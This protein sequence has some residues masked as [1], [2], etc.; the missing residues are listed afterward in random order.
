[1]KLPAILLLL[2]LL[3]PMAPAAAAPVLQP[4]RTVPLVTT[5]TTA[6]PVLSHVRVTVMTTPASFTC[7][8]PAVCI[9]EQDAIEKWGE[10]KYVRDSDQSCG[11]GSSGTQGRPV[12]MY[13]YREV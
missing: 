3:L 11:T 6:V 12:L 10:N 13:C 2:I 8:V 7:T 4:V 1:M 9:S 5:T